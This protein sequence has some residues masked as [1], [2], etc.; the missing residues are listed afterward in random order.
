MLR[1]QRNAQIPLRYR[2]SSPPRLQ[3]INNHQKRRRIG[4]KTVDQNDVDQA[5]AVIEPAPE[6]TDESPILISTE[7]P[8]FEANY[9]PNRIRA[10]QHTDLS[11]LGFF[12]LFFS[13]S[14]VETL[15][16]EINS[17]AEFRL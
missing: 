8:Q 4:L 11:E 10:P 7:L 9:V 1:P 12:E 14:V 5:L 13:H 16:K 3:Q 15:L 2:E 17:Y 6:S